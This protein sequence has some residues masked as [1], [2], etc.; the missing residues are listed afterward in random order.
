MSIA[1]ATS[2]SSART[3]RDFFGRAAAQ[4]PV[5][6]QTQS[7]LHGR[8]RY[9]LA[10]WRQRYPGRRCRRRRRRRPPRPRVLQCAELWSLGG[11]RLYHGSS[12]GSFKVSPG[13]P[14]D[15]QRSLAC[16]FADADGDGDF[17]L[18][19][20]NGPRSVGSRRVGAA[21][22]LFVNDGKGVFSSGHRSELAG[23]R[24]PEQC[25]RLARPRR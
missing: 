2:T 20:A 8:Q 25:M 12:T 17:D 4:P 9:T 22:Q 13:L 14:G 23:R 5:R 18:V 21:N 7:S 11:Q 1:M 19:I 10:R 16:E 15:V 3:T 6:Q 24:R